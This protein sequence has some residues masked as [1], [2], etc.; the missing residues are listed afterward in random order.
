MKRLIPAVIIL[1]SVLSLNCFSDHWI[2]STCSDAMRLAEQCE[3]EW[4]A[5]ENYKSSLSRLREFWD[6]KEYGL[7]FFVN[8]EK[9]S[10]VE[11][12]I[13]SLIENKYD[14]DRSIFREQIES[15]KNLI[16]QIFDDTSL[17]MKNIA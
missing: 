11:L 1:L 2:R 16:Q 8:H 15:L 3:E 6:K 4:I 7:S 17:N 13:N 14:S 5:S 9:L 10:N 12:K